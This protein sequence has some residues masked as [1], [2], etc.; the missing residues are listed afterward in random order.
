MLFIELEKLE[1]TGGHI[2]ISLYIVMEEIEFT[3]GQIEVMLFIECSVI[4]QHCCLR[5]L[6]TSDH[7][8]YL[9]VLLSLKFTFTQWDTFLCLFD[10]CLLTVASCPRSLFTT[11][12]F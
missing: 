2:E 4:L 3:G 1:L 12:G 6:I 10:R 8:I 9:T 11:Y 5:F 7:N